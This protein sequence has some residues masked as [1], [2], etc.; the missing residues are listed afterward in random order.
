[1]AAVLPI[2]YADMADNCR[3]LTDMVGSEKKIGSG[4]KMVL[5]V[6]VLFMN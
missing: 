2:Q 6:Y 1:M 5:K 3:Y 4:V